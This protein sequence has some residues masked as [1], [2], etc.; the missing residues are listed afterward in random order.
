MFVPQEDV[1]RSV[2]FLHLGQSANVQLPVL[3]FEVAVVVSTVGGVYQVH[4]LNY[5]L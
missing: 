5:V 1:D 4:T 3:V 2:R